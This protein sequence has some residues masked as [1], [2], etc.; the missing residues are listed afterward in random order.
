MAPRSRILA[1]GS[2]AGLVVAGG[3]C[4]LFAGGV[5]GQVFTVG[6]I[7]LGFGGVLLLVFYEVGLSE[8]RARARDEERRRRRLADEAAAGSSPRRSRW[9]R[10]PG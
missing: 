10:R 5:L 7:T 6:L 1:Y 3:I 9:P 4:A 2:A 8:D